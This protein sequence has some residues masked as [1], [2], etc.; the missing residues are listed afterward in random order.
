M[1]VTDAASKV[2]Y[3]H[4]ACVLCA[5]WR[6]AQGFVVS[7][8]RLSTSPAM[9]LRGQYPRLGNTGDVHSG[10]GDGGGGGSSTKSLTTASMSLRPAS[11]GA[12][13]LTKVAFQ[14]MLS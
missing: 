3:L 7:S 5:S 14:V 13:L 12:P 9:Y 10:G 2:L 11:S 4:V 1:V 8:A 6:L